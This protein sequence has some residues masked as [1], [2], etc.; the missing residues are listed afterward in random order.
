MLK[1]LRLFL[2]C[3][4]DCVFT[5][6]HITSLWVIKSA[7]EEPYTHQQKK[8][9]CGS[10]A[11]GA[12]AQQLDGGMWENQKGSKA[13]KDAGKG[14]GRRQEQSEQLVKQ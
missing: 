5:H 1:V 8:H 14:A 11:W 12:S 3:T 7:R 13:G 6:V 2:C 10:G 9:S 4:I